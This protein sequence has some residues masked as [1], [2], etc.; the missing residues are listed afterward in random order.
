MLRKPFYKHLLS[1][2]LAGLSLRL[3]FIWRFPFA[4]GDTPC[5]E[6]L[7]RNWLHYGV[8]GLFSNGHLCPSDVRMPGYP[9]FLAAI[10]SVGGVGRSAVFVVQAFIDLATCVLARAKEY[11]YLCDLRLFCSSRL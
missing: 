6:E 10:Y 2:L 7:A 1:A 9:G 8:Y 3:F 4:S 11:R 5:Y